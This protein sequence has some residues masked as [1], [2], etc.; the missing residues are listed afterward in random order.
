MQSRVKWFDNVKGYGFIESEE[1]QD[2]FVHY[3][4]IDGDG[5]KTLREGQQVEFELSQGEKGPL[6]VNVKLV[7]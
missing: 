7:N 5:Y 6:A 4:Q 3:K 2:I 1:G